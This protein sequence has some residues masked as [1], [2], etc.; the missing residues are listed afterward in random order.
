MNNDVAGVASFC[1]RAIMING[2]ESENLPFHTTNF[3]SFV[4]V[5]TLPAGV[6]IRSNTNMVSNFESMNI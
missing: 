5:F 6:D 1:D 2:V 4:T 3:L